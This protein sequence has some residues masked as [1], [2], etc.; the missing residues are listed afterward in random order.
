MNAFL[1]GFGGDRGNK[2]NFRVKAYAS[3]DALPETA[4]ENAIA[5]LTG[6]EITG[7]RFSATRPEG[8]RGLVWF[9]TGD[10]G[11]LEL[12]ILKKNGITLYPMECWQCIGQIWT[13]LKAMV[14]QNGWKE[15]TGYKYLYREGDTCDAVGGSW[16]AEAKAADSSVTHQEY[17]QAPTVQYNAGAMTVYMDAAS[18]KGGIFRKSDKI[19]IT[20]YS[21]LR[22]GGT[23]V[24]H[25]GIVLSIWSEIGAYQYDN[26]V[27]SKNANEIGSGWYLDLTNVPPGEYYIGFSFWAAKSDNKMT[28][29]YIRLE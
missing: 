27:A 13:R 15:L 5:V 9:K 28:F 10:S 7:W 14:Y 19:D 26:M 8:T 1:H 6:E 22:C 24:P 25:G 20:G 29:E 21:R 17:L 23:Y 3:Q 4:E 11:V 16:K 12:E 18:N 2:L